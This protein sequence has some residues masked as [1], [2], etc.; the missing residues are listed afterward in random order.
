MFESCEAKLESG[1]S[2]AVFKL[3]SLR[4]TSMPWAVHKGVVE[5][6]TARYHNSGL[7]DIA[8]DLSLTRKDER[9]WTEM[10]GLFSE[11][12]TWDTL[13][14]YNF[15]HI[16]Q[17]SQRS[18]PELASHSDLRLLI[19]EKVPEWT[20]KNETGH[21]SRFRLELAPWTSIYTDEPLL[22]FALGFGFDQLKFTDELIGFSSDDEASP[23]LAGF[24]NN[25]PDPVIIYAKH[26]GSK[27]AQIRN[28]EILLTEIAAAA[29]MHPRRRRRPVY[30]VIYPQTV[31]LEIRVAD[32][33]VKAAKEQQREE[34]GDQQPRR[35]AMLSRKS[36]AAQAQNIIDNFL[37]YSN[38]DV[39]VLALKG[40]EE[41]EGVRFVVSDPKRYSTAELHIDVNE[42]SLDT[43]EITIPRPLSLHKHSTLAMNL[44]TPDLDPLENLYPLY[45]ITKDCKT[46]LAYME[47]RGGFTGIL[48][49]VDS[50]NSVSKSAFTVESSNATAF[51]V[52]LCTTNGCQPVVVERDLRLTLDVQ[53]TA[54]C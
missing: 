23:T 17:M 2:S 11:D 54:D 37:R 45:L 48:A 36:I 41:D 8:L 39:D 26:A 31:V 34:A 6:F 9:T 25:T 7:A 38:V 24:F 5:K 20:E 19:N 4:S 46:Q 47:K 42:T 27:T 12:I 1:S 30:P 35:P 14:T 15:L 16:K 21:A 53:L 32:T 3:E 52:D 29:G 51:N 13:L 18:F 28:G 10:T 22:W 44:F 49:R 33:S 50:P 40:K 43:A